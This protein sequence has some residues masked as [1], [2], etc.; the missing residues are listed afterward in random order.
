MQSFRTTFFLAI[1]LTV[2]VFGQS[3]SNQ[4]YTTI[5]EKSVTD[6]Y[7]G[8][9]DKSSVQKYKIKNLKGELNNYSG[10]LFD[11]Q[12][13]FDE[14]FYGLSTSGN[15]RKPFDLSESQKENLSKRKYW[16]DSNFTRFQDRSD[17][18]K[19]TTIASF[20]EKE[21]PVF[22][23]QVEVESTIPTPSVENKLETV[24]VV[25]VSNGFGKYFI[26][27]PG[28]SFPYKVHNESPEVGEARREYVPGVS[29]NMATGIEG[30]TFNLGLGVQFKRNSLDTASFYNDPSLGAE[31]ISGKSHTFAFYLDMGFKAEINQH[32]KAYFGTGL[33]YFNTRYHGHIKDYDDGLYG[34]GSIGLEWL[35][36]EAIKFRFGYRYAHEEEVPSHIC[37]AGLNFAY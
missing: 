16:Y 30:E 24:P 19:E 34:T 36:S 23:E 32:L 10:R 17:L 14:I 8:M 22:Q 12:K 29:L 27:H 33:G 3:V 28:V 1:F 21:T 11:L 25:E 6:Y 13:R 9:D 18:A 31:S 26:L 5:S 35:L 15:H 4:Q 37:E 20:P 2:K 7:S